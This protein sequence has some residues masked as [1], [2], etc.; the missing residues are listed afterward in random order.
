MHHSA[1]RL[2]SQISRYVTGLMLLLVLSVGGISTW[3]IK[4]EQDT[5]FQTIRTKN[6]E[7]KAERIAGQINTIYE[8]IGNAANSSLIATALVDSV[9]KE[10]YLVPYLQGFR[11]IQ[12]VPIALVFTDFEGKE[13]ARNGDQGISEAHF[14]WIAEQL[15]AQKESMGVFNSPQ[16][17]ELRGVFFVNYSRTPEP[18]GALF[19][20]VL[21]KDLSEPGVHLHWSKGDSNLTSD[22]RVENP[23]LSV[24]LA[25]PKAFA[26]LDLKVEYNEGSNLD[27]PVHWSLLLEMMAVMAVFIA[28]SALFIR[29]VSD[30][31][32]RDLRNLSEFAKEVVNTGFTEKRAQPGNSAEVTEVSAAVNLMLERLHELHRQLQ[33]ESERK[34]RNL[35]E[36][37]PGAAFMR[38]VQHPWTLSFVS[39]GI[40]NL[41]G[42]SAKDL[43]G[44]AVI[45]YKS[46]VHPEDR[47]RLD[48]MMRSALEAHSSYVCEYRMNDL[49]GQEKW[50][51]E[52]GLAVADSAGQLQINGVLIDITLRKQAEADMEAAKNQAESANMAKSSFLATMSHEIRTPMNGIL[53]M[54]ELLQEANLEPSQR[55]DYSQIILDSAQSLMALLNDILDLSKVEAGKLDLMLTETQVAGMLD[56][57]QGLFVSAADKKGLQFRTS[58]NGARDATYLMD[59]I[60]LRQMLSNLIVNAI[61]FTNSGFVELKAYEVES[62][63]S[64][65]LLHFQV[66]DSG[67]GIA[68]DKQD[69]LFQPFSQVDSS[70]TRRYG[71]SGLGLS[72]VRRFA[73]LMGGTVGCDS[74]YGHGSIF[75]FTV[76]V[77]K[78]KSGTAEPSSVLVSGSTS[79]LPKGSAKQRKS[80]TRLTIEGPVHVL[81]VEDNSTNRMVVSAMLN[82]LGVESRFVFNGQEAVDLLTHEKADRPD[83]VLMDCEM[84]VL[85]GLEA[86]RR[87]RQHEVENSLPRLPIVALTARAYETDRK[88]CLQCGMDDVITKPVGLQTLAEKIS[89]WAACS[90][91][92]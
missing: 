91:L 29:R 1:K 34:F 55:K 71:G 24:P 3:L 81:V 86:T 75:W 36:N 43:T 80:T 84:P 15:K 46:L 21:I 61:K 59:P 10:A 8:Q 39:S 13:I 85:D 22:N 67:V 48:E 58:W 44:D 31:L 17:P 37:L 45:S 53:G 11:Q 56:D 79:G 7:V 73:E 2:S 5:A 66:R 87:I 26:P 25:L 14:K 51:W 74:E 68:A 82:K 60:R 23:E 72:I 20:R 27:S 9:G 40:G 18:E 70:S 65:C 77:Q 90:T 50:V 30:H 4:N 35:V 42:Y 89:T 76:K 88:N 57:I 41:C 19:Y 78:M 47:A 52:R 62:S 6:L 64:N 92:K 12:G 16:G 49:A 33:D 28:L 38:D 54:A 63:G 83:L 32:T 69:L